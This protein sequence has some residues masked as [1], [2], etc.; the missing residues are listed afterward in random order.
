MHTYCIFNSYVNLCQNLAS[1]FQ[2]FTVMSISNFYCH[3]NFKLLQSCQFQT[4]AVTSSQLQS[5]STMQFAIC[6]AKWLVRIQEQLVPVNSFLFS[7]VASSRPR[8]ACACQF[9][10]VIGEVASSNPRTACPGQFPAII[11]QVAS[12]NPRTACPYQFPAIISQVASSYPRTACACQFAPV[13]SQVASSNTGTA[14]AYLPVS[15]LGQVPSSS[16]KNNLYLSIR[17]LFPQ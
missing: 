10:S 3:V 11:S 17:C 8:T 1:Q 7:Q 16:Q 12:S 2:T 4:P 9:I 6:S 14:C 15:F 5:I 13:I